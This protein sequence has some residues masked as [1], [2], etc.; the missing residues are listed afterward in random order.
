[1]LR[2][3]S[4]SNSR[5]STSS[6]RI[7]FRQMMVI[8]PFHLPSFICSHAEACLYSIKEY[9]VQE[10][11]GGSETPELVAL[12][13][14]NGGSQSPDRWLR[15]GRNNHISFCNSIDNIPISLSIFICSPSYSSYQSKQDNSMSCLWNIFPVP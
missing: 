11:Q 5:L 2:T 7:N 13:L 12:I 14:R 15:E 4:H 9:M 8:N 10:P 6:T 1:M 3:S